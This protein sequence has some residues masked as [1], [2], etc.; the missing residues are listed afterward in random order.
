MAQRI[1][2]VGA[3]YV[4]IV[5]WLFDDDDKTGTDL[6]N[7][8]VARGTPAKLVICQCGQDVTN[9][10]S[11][12]DEQLQQDGKYPVIH[13]EAHGTE[14]GLEGPSAY[15]FSE[16]LS[17]ETLSVPLRTLNIRTSFN[18]IVVGAAC[19]GFSVYTS[20]DVTDTAP[21]IF[22]IGFSEKINPSSL[23]RV[24]SE[25]YRGLFASHKT[26]ILDIVKD[27]NGE[28]SE[29]DKSAL[30]CLNIVDLGKYLAALSLILELNE[31]PAETEKHINRLLEEAKKAQ[32]PMTKD[33]AIEWRKSYGPTAQQTVMDK[34]FA[35][36]LI[37]EN[38][39]RFFIDAKTIYEGVS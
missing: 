1:G 7:V 39:E 2:T 27:A 18:L 5:E 26:M 23:R 14:D 36:D 3:T 32:R 29:P 35:Y 37:P 4:L 30:K 9:A 34:W 8:L 21:F 11:V 6:Y 31:P 33:E 28:L 19:H 24:T 16:G 38:R 10:L 12:A 17:W 13:L 20:F 22:A 15:G 25:L